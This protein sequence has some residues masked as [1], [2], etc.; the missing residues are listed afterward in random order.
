MSLTLEKYHELKK[1][2]GNP[3]TI[4]CPYCKYD[5]SDLK[6]GRNPISTKMMCAKCKR[7]FNPLA[8]QDG[9]ENEKA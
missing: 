7:Y 9:G 2:A 5:G 6:I 1:L 8:N 4:V 3:I